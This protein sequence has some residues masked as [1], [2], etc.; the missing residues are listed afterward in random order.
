MRGVNS[1]HVLM[2][3]VNNEKKS[4]KICLHFTYRRFTGKDFIYKEYLFIH[5]FN[6]YAYISENI[7]LI[8]HF[9]LEE[10]LQA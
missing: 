5:I 9:V 8:C 4:S 10:F 2:I 7:S 1:Y 3:K 6:I